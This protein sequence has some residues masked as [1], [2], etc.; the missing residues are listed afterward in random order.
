MT[1]PTPLNPDALAVAE[2]SVGDRWDG[3]S[4]A[5]TAEEI[6]E[7][8]IRAYLAALSAPAVV[9]A[10]NPQALNIKGWTCGCEP[11]NYD[12]CDECQSACNELA[13]F[14]H[15]VVRGQL[16]DLGLQGSS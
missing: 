3:N 13:S 14:L 5:G 11:G 15:G 7:G 12:S 4:F 16:T 6:A 9:E 8:A 1:N 2:F 10:F